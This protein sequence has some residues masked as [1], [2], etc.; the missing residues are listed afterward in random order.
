MPD[1][2]RTLFTDVRVFDG[3]AESLSGPARVLSEDG[4]ITAIGRTPTTP[5]SKPP[6]A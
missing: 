2:S 5:A 4:I 3:I 1:H 6:I